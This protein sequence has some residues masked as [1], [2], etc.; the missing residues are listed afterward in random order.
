M[1][2][3]VGRFYAFFRRYKHVAKVFL[4]A[5]IRASMKKGWTYAHIGP[6]WGLLALGFLV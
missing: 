4:L 3:R 1:K 6:I 2:R 5:N